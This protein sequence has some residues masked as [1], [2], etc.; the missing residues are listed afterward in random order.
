M[1]RK[2]SHCGRTTTADFIHCQRCGHELPSLS[3]AAA[4]VMAGKV[5]CSCSSYTPSAADPTLCGCCGGAVKKHQPKADP[6][7]SLK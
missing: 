1:N 7:K 4:A 2:C 6:N 5:D 3:A